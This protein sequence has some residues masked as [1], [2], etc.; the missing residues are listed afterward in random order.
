[1]IEDA[2]TSSIVGEA[3]ERLRDRTGD[4][5]DKIK[6]VGAQASSAA[7]DIGDK[8]SGLLGDAKASAKNMASGA[9]AKANDAFEDQKTAGANKIKG[10]SG[11]IRRAAD[12][13]EGELPPAATYIRRAADE[14]DSMTDAVQRRDVR[15]ILSDVQGFARRQ[16]AAFLG[17][18]VLGGFAVMRLLRTPTATHD[19]GENAHASGTG[20][21][22]VAADL[23]AGSPFPL[24]RASIKGGPG[25]PGGMAPEAPGFKTTGDTARGM[26]T[27]MG[28]GFGTNKP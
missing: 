15:Q 13:L 14:I 17:A 2:K 7:Q 27:G 1:M 10:I 18:T 20:R 19:T 6:G 9:G 11:A 22:L 21:S 28:A 5:A 4:A 8:A 3:A 23:V 12:E 16:P 25:D 26:D 24:D